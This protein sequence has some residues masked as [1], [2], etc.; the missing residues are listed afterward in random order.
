MKHKIE[1]TSNLKWLSRFDRHKRLEYIFFFEEQTHQSFVRSLLH[2]GPLILSPCSIEWC[3]FQGEYVMRRGT[4]DLLVLFKK[5]NVD[6]FWFLLEKGDIGD[7]AFLCVRLEPSVHNMTVK[8]LLKRSWKLQATT[9]TSL[10][11]L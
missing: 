3:E 2:L 10:N 8:V 7:T 4:G 1:K 6:S 11:C 5:N 9:P